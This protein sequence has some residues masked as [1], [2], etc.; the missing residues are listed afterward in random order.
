MIEW[1]TLALL[2]FPE[3][4]KRAQDELDAVVGRGRLPSFEDRAHLPYNVALLREVLRWRTGLPLGVA[5]LSEDDDYYEGMFIP[6]GSVLVA[7][8]MPCNQDPEVYGDD[9]QLFKPERHLD[10][11]GRLAPAPSTTKDQGHVSFGFGRRVCVGQHVA[12]DALFIATTRM[13]WSFSFEKARDK[14]GRA[15]EVDAVGYDDAGMIL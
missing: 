13:L 1:W 9:A 5:H 10:E 4:Q 12:L 6:K 8:I 15:V 2:A 3:V 11:H 7:N 14:D